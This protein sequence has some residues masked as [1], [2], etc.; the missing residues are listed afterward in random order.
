MK[1]R[2]KTLTII[3]H[4]SEHLKRLPL[5]IKARA[6]LYEGDKKEQ[7]DFLFAASAFCSKIS[8]HGRTLKQ[9]YSGESDWGFIQQ[10]QQ[11]IKSAHPHCQVI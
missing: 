6:G 5:S 1:N 4:L 7:A 11:R 10:L 2:E 8:I 9:L 3:Q